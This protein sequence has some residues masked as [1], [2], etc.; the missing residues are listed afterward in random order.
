MARCHDIQ[1]PISPIITPN[2][3]GAYRELFKKV[4]GK[5]VDP[6]LTTSPSTR[7]SF[8]FGAVE[9]KSASGDFVEAYTQMYVFLCALFKRYSTF[10]TEVPSPLPGLITTGHKWLFYISWFDNTTGTF[11]IHGPVEIVE[12]STET[13]YGIFKII[14]L[15]KR[16][17]M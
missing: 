2:F 6:G 13:Y 8:I 3:T 15:L 5:Q 7:N 12:C 16:L 1:N 14:D 10:A 9:T 17:R 4:R 11:H